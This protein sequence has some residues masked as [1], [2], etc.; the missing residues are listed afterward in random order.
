MSMVTA[1]MFYKQLTGSAAGAITATIIGAA[2]LGFCA[3]F[4]GTQLGF[5]N[6]LSIVFLVLFLACIGL[7]IFFVV[8]AARMKQH[9]V[10]RRYGNAAFLAERINQGL[11]NP[12]YLIGTGGEIPFGT[13]ITNDFIV[14]YGE[15]TGFMELKD[16]RT[17]QIA[18]IPNVHTY[19]ISNPLT[20]A[21]SAAANYA[22]D[23][24][25][26]SKGVNAQT[27]CDLLLM[28]DSDGKQHQYSVRHMDAEAV[29]NL[30]QQIA[31]HITINRDVR[32]M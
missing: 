2:I 23:K 29:L 6:L 19:N 10:F 27:R 17:A 22:G 30:L 24:Y 11:Q 4:C 26:E 32:R 9:A 14:D 20:L 12:R 21:A 25:M 13:L 7:L 1:Q 8:R 18:V 3:G 5:G 15:L 31:P 16:L 28:K